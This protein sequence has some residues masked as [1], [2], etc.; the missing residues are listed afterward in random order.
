MPDTSGSTL[1]LAA[2]P[3]PSPGP[4]EQLVLGFDRD[5]QRQFDIAAIH[6]ATG[7]Y[8]APPE[9]EALLTR[10]NWPAEGLRLLDPGAGNA[11]VLVAAL[12]RLDLARDDVAEAVNRVKGYEFHDGAVA[13]ARLAVRDHLARRGWSARAAWRAA[14]LDR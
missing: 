4:G 5:Q 6:Q 9:I 11:G 2:S 14:L 3:L 7:I 12:S 8:T 13:E 10:L 1:R